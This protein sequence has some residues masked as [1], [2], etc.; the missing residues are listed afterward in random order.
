MG[1]KW[2]GARREIR[3]HFTHK[4]ASRGLIR[5]MPKNHILLVDDEVDYVETLSMILQT[6]GYTVSK[7]YSSE[8]GLKKAKE[9]PNLILLDVNIPTVSGYEVC[10]KLR[11]D[12]ATKHIPIIILTGKNMPKDKVEG[13]KIGADDYITKSYN[14]EELFARIEALLRRSGFVEEIN[15][16][17]AVLFEE[18]KGIIK[19]EAVKMLFQPLFELNPR[20]LF[21][22]EVLTR[23][24]K[25]SKLERPD[26]LFQYALSC[27]LLPDLE[28][29]CRKK[30]LAKLGDDIEKNLIFFNTNPFLIE[31]E[32]FKDILDLYNMPQQVV[33]EI[34]ERSEIKN[35]PAFC[36]IIKTFKE[37]GFRISIDD[38]GSGY[39][40]LDSIAELKP[41]FVK[42]DMGL[43]RD[44]GNNTVKQNLV[45]A[46]ASLCKESRI[47]SIGEGIETEDELKMLIDLKVEA[48]QGYLLGKPGPEL[49]VEKK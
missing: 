30:A 1:G 37:K 4:E 26:K 10:N 48:G 8:E 5:T 17:Q 46:I 6:R 44:I 7:A 27:G 16:D 43:I 20:K 45:K 12:D 11:Q 24:P 42:I 35:F 39:S 38:V 40:S 15:K 18:L 31:T 14:L 2:A 32:S 25:D 47:I 29:V 41:D 19:D 9:K 28:L 22:Y 13:L 33:L 21:G 49:V 34:T 23:G 3:I 36:K